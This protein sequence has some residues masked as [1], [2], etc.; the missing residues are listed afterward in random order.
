MKYKVKIKDTIVYS[1]YINMRE[2]EYEKLCSEDKDIILNT[3]RTQATFTDK[4]DEEELVDFY[5]E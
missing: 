3:I 5:V 2:E 4:W 1:G